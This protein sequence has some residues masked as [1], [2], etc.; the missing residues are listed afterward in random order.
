MSN[1]PEDPLRDQ[2]ERAIYR[3]LKDHPELVGMFL[4]T[5]AWRIAQ[6]A[7]AA[8]LE[9]GASAEPPEDSP[10]PGNADR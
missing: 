7:A 1:P 4:Y 3:R 10:K 6:H 8:V 2:L 9:Y 5:D